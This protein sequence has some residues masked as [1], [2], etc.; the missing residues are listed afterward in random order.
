MIR[1]NCKNI[2]HIGVLL[3]GV[4]IYTRLI[5]QENLVFNRIST[6]DG[7]SQSSIFCI[8][9][10][11][12][13]FMWFGTQYGLNRYDGYAFRVFK[14]EPKNP[15]SISDNYIQSILVDKSGVLWIGTH[16]GGLNKFNPDTQDFD[17]YMHNEV[18]H[19]SIS[20]NCVLCIFEDKSNEIWIGTVFGLNKMDQKTELF[21][22]YTNDKK[23]IGSLC[24]NEVWNIFED[25]DGE[26][27]IGTDNGLDKFDRRKNRFTHFSHDEKNSSSLCYNRIRYIYEDSYGN[28]WIGTRNGLDKF[29]RRKNCFFH[30]KNDLDNPDSLSSN[31]IRYICEDRSKNLWIGTMGGIN[32][33]DREKNRFI[34]FENDS[35]NPLSLSQNEVQSIYEDKAGILWIGVLGGIN[36]VYRGTPGFSRYTFS[37]VNPTF[38]PIEGSRNKN[39]IWS[40]CEDKIGTLWIGSYNGLTLFNRH[41]KEAYK[42]Y[43]HNENNL[44][45][46]SENTVRVIYEDS[47]G[48][49]W[50]G[51]YYGG[52]DKF[53]RGTGTFSHFNNDGLS[54]YPI[55]AIQEDKQK[56]IWIGTDGDGL[57]NI[58]DRSN[59]KFKQYNYKGKGR[60]SLSDNKIL[61][62]YEDS[63]E[64][65]WIGT[66][67]GGLNKLMDLEK[68]IF[69]SYT[70]D[71]N[72]TDS[73]S[74]NRVRCIHETRSR[75]LW[76]GTECGLNKFDRDT[77]KFQSFFEKD[78]L[79]SEVVYSILSDSA[80]NL[81]MSTMNGLARFDPNK[82]VFNAYDF[83]DGLQ[84]N[85]FNQGA[86][87][88]NSKKELFFGGVNG[89][90]VFLPEN[91]KED[92]YN[93]PI[94]ITDFLIFNKS[95]MS[96]KLK[97]G[98]LTL[99]PRENIFSIEFAALHYA[100]PQKNRY[101]Y[102]LV[103]YDRDW[104]NTDYKNRRATYTNVPHGIYEFTVRGTNIDGI[105][106]SNT[107]SIKIKILPPWNKT[108]WAYLL[109]SLL[110]CGAL[111]LIWFVWQNKKKQ[112]RE[113]TRI[114]SDLIKKQEE[115]IKTHTKLIQSEKMAS[116]GIL[117]AGVAHQMNNPA[118]I[119]DLAVYNLKNDMQKFKEF[120]T[121]ISGFNTDDE[122][123]NIFDIK[124]NKFFS[125]MDT[126]TRGTT[127]ITENVRKLLEFSRPSKGEFKRVK[128]AELLQTNID[129]I[130]GKYTDHVNFAT[131]FQANPELKCDPAK[132]NEAFMNIMINACQAIIK[133]QNKT[134]QKTKGTLTIQTHQEN[135]EVM[136]IFQDTGIGMSKKV[137]DNMFAPFFT[138]MPEG[139]G[140]GLGLSISYSIIQEHKGRIEVKSEEGE[141]A[142]FNIV[143]PLENTDKKETV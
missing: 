69:I 55:L 133:C 99:S 138:A 130:R 128:L 20:H 59:K 117:T 136:I 76:I 139:E 110:I 11:N 135:N 2:L 97:K 33:F 131:D 111:L 31:E 109:F 81:W 52:L 43:T 82:K 12:E 120:L 1:R 35:S 89:F 143:L 107:A 32:R 112:T 67:S 137:Q 3:M 13:G 64:V 77:E 126:I 115:L 91:I 66:W 22:H 42:Y 125:Y 62:L 127:R 9:Q 14:N 113:L 84:G 74:N 98:R 124:F 119:I 61:C 51:T 10:D 36:K 73:I 16:D 122:I 18:T 83:N 56:N 23:D 90:N 44:R 70:H 15:R 140:T 118:S 4:L 106:S 53:N 17:R 142:S 7:L 104:I 100:N 30:Y 39:M 95:K 40:I 50:I 102:K 105:L 94:V 96:Q 85:E 19:N 132:L 86:F 24:N 92:T 45:S 93:S 25:R 78:G 48:V 27:W 88:K 26:L 116:I 28:F 46:L 103:D 47:G 57:Y 8:A 141:G 134:D 60:N 72:K 114:N 121:D 129:F 37:T 54:K 21:T 108:M 79:P 6:A 34:H 75:E 41:K 71:D 58:L 68:E 29:E 63:R 123:R 49:I 5:S 38:N 101:N 87:F 80:G 65:L